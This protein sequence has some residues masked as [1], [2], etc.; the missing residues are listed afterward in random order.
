MNDSHPLKILY[1]DPFFV[2]VN[3]PAG[4]LVHRSR[5]A[6]RE[7]RFAL[8]M[9]RDR[10]GR[11]VYPVHRLDRP[12]QGV[13]L[14]ALSPETANKTARMFREGRVKKR[15]IA[16]VR[17]HTRE[18][19]AIDHPLGKPKDKRDP[20]SGNRTTSPAVTAYRRL[21][22]VELPFA[23]DKYPTSRYCLVELRPETGRR[24]QL[25]RHMKHISH[26]IIGDRIYG[27]GAHNRFFEE[28]FGCPG[29][30]LTAVE[31]AFRHP[32]TGEAVTLSAGVNRRF[33]ALLN[34]L[35]WGNAICFEHRTSNV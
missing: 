29:L 28:R 14:F 2:A 26:P 10:I 15:Y 18:R 4:L 34:R 12:T 25:R 9:V 6:G 35:G 19:G 33:G 21:A 27:K 31:L 7:K 20:G 17:G 32:E 8:Q 24:H 30:L 5:L 11:R 16:L 23:V 13:L 22:T 3:K 1:R